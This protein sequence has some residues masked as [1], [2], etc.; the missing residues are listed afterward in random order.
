MTDTVLERYLHTNRL[1]LSAESRTSAQPE[2][3][4]EDLGAFG[5]LRGVRERAIML[6]LRKKSGNVMAIGYS[7][8][9]RV[10]YDPSSG[11][12]LHALGRA[13]RITGSNLN[14][15]QSGA[16]RLFD[17]IVRHRVTW[18]QETGTSDPRP[19]GPGR[20]VIDTIEW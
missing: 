19:D 10:E 4:A 14:T 3:A 8:I 9:E 7:W 12:T 1:G 13:V 11:L 2:E 18:I 5:W 17:G 20:T 16:A 15:P 6:E